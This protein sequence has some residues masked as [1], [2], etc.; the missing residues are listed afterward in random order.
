VADFGRSTH[1]A[2]FA[3]QIEGDVAPLD[4]DEFPRFIVHVRDEL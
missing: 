1:T 4:G 3:R 2:A